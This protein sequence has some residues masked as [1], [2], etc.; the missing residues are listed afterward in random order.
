MKTNIIPAFRLTL[1]MLLL[2]SGLYT[3]MV[4]AAAQIVPGG[5]HGVKVSSKGKTWYANIGQQFTDDRYFQGRPSAVQYNASASGGSNKG[6]YDHEY[7]DTVRARIETFLQHNPTVK[8]SEIPVALV[9][10][11]GSGLDPD[12][13]PEAALVQVNRVAAIRKLDPAKLRTLIIRQTHQ[14]LWDFMGPQ[15]INVLQLNIALDKLN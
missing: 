8:K 12:I 6:P 13:S 5:G 4:Y 1:V 10:A 15:K 11:S 14:P 2:C 3:M 7:V 9:T